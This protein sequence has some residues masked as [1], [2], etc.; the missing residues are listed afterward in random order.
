M[1]IK[2]PENQMG[3]SIKLKF[4]KKSHGRGSPIADLNVTPMVDMLTMLV[5]FLLMTFSATGEVLFVTPDI[6]LPKA[7]HAVPLDR[8]PVIAVSASAIVVEGEQ[9][10]RTEEANERWYRDWRLPPVVRQLKKLAKDAKEMHPD[11]PFSGSV[12]IQ[13]DGN[14]PFSVIK[15]LMTSCGEAGYFDVNFAVQY[16]GTGA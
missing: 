10:M 13:S 9:V 11:K 2:K 7:F 12:I 5:I 3:H 16:I 4:A 15:M 14:V 1:L 8:S 6:V